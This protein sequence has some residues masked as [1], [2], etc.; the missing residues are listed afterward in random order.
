M[1]AAKI[2][3]HL[4]EAFTAGTCCSQLQSS[5]VQLLCILVKDW[6]TRKYLKFFSYLH[7]RARKM[8]MQM[9]L[10]L[11]LKHTHYLKKRHLYYP[12]VNMCL[13]WKMDLLF[14]GSVCCMSSLI[15]PFTKAS[16]INTSTSLHCI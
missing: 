11:V 5:S 6:G 2:C 13:T 12:K 4:S 1:L 9:N 16:I 14:P 10:G 15:T 3:K 7:Q 8:T